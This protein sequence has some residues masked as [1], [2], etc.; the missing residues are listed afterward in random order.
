MNV[1]SHKKTCF[2]D[3]YIIKNRFFYDI[4][5]IDPFDKPDPDRSNICKVYE[6]YQQQ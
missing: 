3:Y 2:F 1:V 5:F 6:F 4:F